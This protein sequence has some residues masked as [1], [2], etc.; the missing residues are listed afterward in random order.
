[1]RWIVRNVVLGNSGAEQGN[2]LM[3]ILFVME[4]I[5]VPIKQMS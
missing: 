1:M 5:N 3:V 4:H 2:V